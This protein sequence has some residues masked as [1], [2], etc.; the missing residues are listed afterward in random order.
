M[1]HKNYSTAKVDW[2]FCDQNTKPST[3]HCLRCGE[4]VPMCNPPG[5]WE[6]DAMSARLNGFTVMH[7]LCKPG[8]G[9]V[10]P[11]TEEEIAKRI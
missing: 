3:I 6:V 5:W 10:K 2:V 11:F 4:R 7:S 9:H 8:A 1:A